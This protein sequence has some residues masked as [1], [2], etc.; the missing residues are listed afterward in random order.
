MRCG[1]WFGLEGQH[2][3]DDAERN[4]GGAPLELYIGNMWWVN[5]SN[6][7]GRTI[8]QTMTE[9]KQKGLNMI[10]LPIAPQTLDPND[11]QGK[12]DGVL[13]NHPSVRQD[14]ARQ[15]MEDFIKLADK[16]DIQVLIDIHSCSNYVGWRAGRLDA[17]PPYVDATREGYNFTRE[18]YSCGGGAANDQP[19]NKS[20]WLSDLKEIAGLSESLGVD[21]II[22]IDIF[23]EPWDYTWSEWKSL[24]E[25][26]YDAIN[27]VNS[28]MLVFVEGIGSETSAGTEIAHGVHLTNPNWGENF[29]EAKDNPLDIPKDR[30]VISP[31]TYGPSV[32]VQRQFMDPSDSGCAGLEGDEAASKGCNIVINPSL[33][34]EGWEEHFGFLRDQ[35]FAVV[36][37]EFGGNIEWPAKT[38]SAEQKAWSH[39]TPGV[40]D[41]AWQNAF[42][43]YM[44]EEN[45][46]GCYWSVNPESGD[47]GGWYDSPYVV[48]TAESYWGQ[49]T[50]LNGTKTQLLTRLWNGVSTDSGSTSGGSSNSGSDNSGS[51]NSGDSGNDNSGDSGSDNSGSDNSGSD[52]GSD[53]SGNNNS[54][55]IGSA[56]TTSTGTV[57]LSSTK[58]V[59]GTFDGGCKTYMPTW[60]DCGQQEGQDPVFRVNG[61]TLKNV[62][63]GS[64]GDGVHVY[65]NATIENVTWPDVCEDA[66]TVKKEAT[67][68]IK[69]ISGYDAADKF[70]QLNAKATVTVSNS[71]VD[72]VLKMF[73]ENGGKCYPVNVT[74]K[75]SE[76]TNVREAIFRTDCSS[77][78]FTMTNTKTSGIKAVCKGDGQCNY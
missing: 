16:N 12:G 31:H 62:I 77:S 28:D 68:N 17:N 60:G 63:V 10:R 26:A 20:K 66:L 6:G 34:R 51:D 18:D 58:V 40:V 19:Y 41:I 30:L 27:S 49:W 39:I 15:A 3:P 53:N 33:L 13:K 75:N 67:V 23:N 55:G 46:Q 9:I 56:C 37:G 22:G 11:P 69:N 38:R 59:N 47:T 43:D 29:F 65:G 48:E 36:M 57:S 54:S 5:S 52:S 42:V 61:G 44:V 64:R 71:K 73:R 35:G 50:G 2:E 4:A 76:V 1:N 70:I 45:I 78:K 72:N 24:A 8:Q 14:N 7:S 25:S 74:V 32:F 21:N